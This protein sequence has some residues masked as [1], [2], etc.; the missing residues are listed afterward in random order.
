MACGTDRFP[1][2]KCY[3]PILPLLLEW[4]PPTTSTC[5]TLQTAVW[6]AQTYHPIFGWGS[7]EDYLPPIS[8]L[9]GAV[10][11]PSYEAYTIPPADISPEIWMEESFRMDEDI[12]QRATRKPNACPSFE[13]PILFAPRIQRTP[14]QSCGAAWHVLRYND[15]RIVFSPRPKARTLQREDDIRRRLRPRSKPAP[16]YSPPNHSSSLPPAP[17]PSSSSERW[18]SDSDYDS[19]SQSSY[20]SSASSARRLSPPPGPRDRLTRMHAPRPGLLEGFVDTIA[21]LW[22][23]LP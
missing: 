2:L 15:A 11:P 16:R 4:T 22:S 13:K 18:D 12:P 17:S 8:E 6:T 14:T 20:S 9:A 3:P 1:S 23:A 19:A 5:L 10:P 21:S 7:T